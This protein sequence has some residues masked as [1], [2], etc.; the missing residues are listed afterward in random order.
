MTTY[1]SHHSADLVSRNSFTS[2][3]QR[4]FAV[5][6]KGSRHMKVGNI[7]VVIVPGVDL[8][9]AVVKES[10]TYTREEFSEHSAYQRF[11]LDRLAQLDSVEAALKDGH[12]LAA[13]LRHL[14][15]IER[16]ME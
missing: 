2:E 10:M 6:G 12:P 5:Y 4:F 15:K 14:I 7:E 3:A 11:R 8:W 1:V 13:K 9:A 16:E